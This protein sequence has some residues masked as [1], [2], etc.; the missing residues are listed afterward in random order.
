MP[1]TNDFFIIEGDGSGT[2]QVYGDVSHQCHIQDYANGIGHVFQADSGDASCSSD[3]D[4]D[5][6]LQQAIE[7]LLSNES[8]TEQGGYDGEDDSPTSSEC[9]KLSQ[10]TPS[11]TLFL[12][13]TSSTDLAIRERNVTE[14]DTQGINEVPKEDKGE[15]T[16]KISRVHFFDTPEIIEFY[17]NVLP[18]SAENQNNLISLQSGASNREESQPDEFIDV[19]GSTI[20]YSKS[21]D[22]DRNLRIKEQSPNISAEQ[23]PLITMTVYDDTDEDEFPNGRQGTP[24]TE[25]VYTS[26]SDE[27][28]MVVDQP[29]CKPSHEFIFNIPDFPNPH[30]DSDPKVNIRHSNELNLPGSSLDSSDENEFVVKSD[31]N[32][33]IV[34]ISNFILSA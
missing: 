22:S 29:L 32:I 30:G 12:L 33:E 21:T 15:N 18:P 9:F 25:G 13:G 6:D 14:H 34:S 10:A 28:T 3:D 16:R 27:Y 20:L 11:E 7:E 24:V 5:I 8:E 26:E 19:T 23:I 2:A 17:E 31:I 1:D 4:D